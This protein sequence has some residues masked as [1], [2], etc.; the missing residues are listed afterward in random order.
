MEQPKSFYKSDIFLTFLIFII[1]TAVFIV[2]IYSILKKN[3]MMNIDRFRCDPFFMNYISYFGIDGVENFKYCVKNA[4]TEYLGHVLQPVNN[5]ID[6]LNTSVFNLSD[7]ILNI[8]DF[9]NELR[10][11]ISGVVDKIYGSMDNLAIQSNKIQQKNNDNM[12]KLTGAMTNSI[13]LLDQT[14]K[15]LEDKYLAYTPPESEFE[16]E[17]DMLVDEITNTDIIFQ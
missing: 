4:Q 11:N 17:Q 9:I 7:S 14:N 10:G 16:E 2:I 1:F 6:V 5:S 12:S 3:I 8:Q 13:Y 15:S